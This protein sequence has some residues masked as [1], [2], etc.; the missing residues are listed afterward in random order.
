MP[1]RE[2]KSTRS[3]FTAEEKNAHLVQRAFGKTTRHRPPGNGTRI[4]AFV[5]SQGKR[6][7]AK[8]DAR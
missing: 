6:N 4:N 2:K 1:A 8:R 5:V 7:Q 3:T